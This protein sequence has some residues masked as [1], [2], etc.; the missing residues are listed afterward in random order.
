MSGISAS[1]K[2]TKSFYFPDSWSDLEIETDTSDNDTTYT[3][4]RPTP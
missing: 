4:Q 3:I 1:A 2:M